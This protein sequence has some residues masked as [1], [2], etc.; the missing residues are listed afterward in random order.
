Q[1]GSGHRKRAPVVPDGRDALHFAPLPAARPGSDFP[2]PNGGALSTAHRSHLAAVRM[3]G[4]RRR[5]AT[6]ELDDA[7]GRTPPRIVESG[8]ITGDLA[9]PACNS[10]RKRAGELGIAAVDQQLEVLV[11]LAAFPNH[12]EAQ[13]RDRNVV[14]APDTRRSPRIEQHAIAIAA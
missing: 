9:R 4:S 5:A 8:G 2:A 13:R 6:S 12:L 7:F 11:V 3:G 1:K 14:H 10:L